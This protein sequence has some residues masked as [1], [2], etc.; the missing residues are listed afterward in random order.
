MYQERGKMRNTY[1]KALYNLAKNDKN[2]VSLV[3]DN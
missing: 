1:L 3:A 2:I